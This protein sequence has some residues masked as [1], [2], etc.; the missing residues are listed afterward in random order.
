MNFISRLLGFDHA[1]SIDSVEFS[2][3][4]PWATNGLLVFG[5]CVVGLLIASAFYTKFEEQ[6]STFVI[7]S[8]TAMRASLLVL[9]VLTLAAP[10]VRSSATTHRQPRVLVVIDNTESMSLLAGD[11][12]GK[13][14]RSRAERAA[15]LLAGEGSLFGKL[16][17]Q[18]GY[19]LSFATFTGA[20]QQPLEAVAW[21][22]LPDRLTASGPRTDLSAVLHEMASRADASALTACVLISDFAQGEF[23]KSAAAPWPSSQQPARGESWLADFP[24]PVW[25]IGVGQTNP[26]DLA[27]TIRGEKQAKLGQATTLELDL[28]QQGLTDRRTEV[29]VYARALTRSSD[30]DRLP[31]VVHAG[32][33]ALAA[34]DNTLEVAFTPEWAGPIELTA[35]ARSLDGELLHQNNTAAHRVEVIADHLRLLFV[36]QEPTWEWRFVKEVFQRDE[37]IGLDGFRTFLGSADNA[38]K[39]TNSL[40]LPE[41]PASR[42]DFFASDLVLL[43][44]VPAAILPTE[45]CRLLEEFVGDFGGSLV[46]LAGPRFA[47]T[48]FLD[49]P[50]AGML[51]VRLNAASELRDEREFALRVTNAADRYPFMTLA[52]SPDENERAWRGLGKLPWYFPVAGVHEQADVLA[53]HPEDLCSDGRTRQP[54]IA[55]RPYGNGQVVYFAFNEL[56]RLRSGV[57]QKYHRR[58]W[59]QLAYRLGMSH[60]V[61]ERKRFVVRVDERTPRAGDTATLTVDAFDEDFQP[62]ERELSATVAFRR[63]LVDESGGWG[64]AERAP[65]SDEGPPS[66]P[67]NDS[68]SEEISLTLKSAGRYE[69]DVELKAPGEYQLAVTDP[70]INE[71]HQEVLRVSSSSQE[72]QNAARDAGLQRRIADRTGGRMYELEDADRL[73]DELRL[74]PTVAHEQ[75]VI[76]LWHTPLWFVLIAGLMLSEWTVRRWVHL[77]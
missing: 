72:L 18:S 56:W 6:R 71:I 62:L 77:R 44:D 74:Q 8:L 50:I 69:A 51:P 67:S 52:D 9:L 55:I 70:V 57:G 30:A 59:S 58:L 24:V 39:R 49:T 33:F 5:C 60:P 23:A 54:L 48:Q 36:E 73:L 27:I 16:A 46:V 40:F 2:L 20:S 32:E 63:D 29:M 45:F 1:Q 68:V 66:V 64:R 10:L 26:A 31:Q 53:E 28:R 7:R 37:L 42:A 41:L 12:G 3:S 43:G 17:A 25:T 75:R 76:A 22:D 65:G 47:P 11:P 4:A 14:H 35:V 15:E 38:V 19:R 21:S 34:R 13:S 61:G